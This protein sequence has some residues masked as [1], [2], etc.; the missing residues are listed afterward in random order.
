MNAGRMTPH[1]FGWLF[2][3]ALACA[4]AATPSARADTLVYSNGFE[5]P[6]GAEWSNPFVSTT[7]SGRGF[8]GE[9]G[10][11]PVALSVDGIGAHSSVTVEFEVYIIQTW[12]GSLDRVGPDIWGLRVVDGPGLVQ[13]TFANWGA[14]TAYLGL[15]RERDALGYGQGI[16]GDA[17]Y[18]MSFTFPHSASDLVLEFFASGIGGPG[19]ESWGIDNLALVASS[20]AASPVSSPPDPPTGLIAIA[21]NRSAEVSWTPAAS[22]GTG[23]DRYQVFQQPATR[24][25]GWLL[26]DP[27]TTRV[28]RDVA[29]DG[30]PARFRVM[31]VDTAGN[32]GLSEWSNSV[33]AFWEP[34]PGVNQITNGDFESGELGPWREHGGADRVL[35][36][37][38]PYEGAASLYIRSHGVGWWYG[39]AGIHHL[40]PE[41][42]A[43]QQYTLSAFMKAEAPRMVHMRAYRDSGH[44][45]HRGEHALHVGTEW[46]EYYVQFT[47]ND[48]VLPA[49]VAIDVAESTTGLWV[50]DVRFYEGSYQPVGTHPALAIVEPAV[51]YAV[52][53]GNS[54][55]V[56]VGVHNHADGWHWQVDTPLPASG[57]AGGTAVP[58]GTVANVTGLTPG[59]AHTFYA[60][61]VDGSGNV[62]QPSVVAS[63]QLSVPGD[64]PFVLDDEPKVNDAGYIVSWLHLDEP[65][66]TS[67]GAV[68]A[69]TRDTIGPE[70]VVLA[71]EGGLAPMGVDLLT[72]TWQRINFDDVTEM[73]GL[74]PI[75]HERLQNLMWRH[76]DLSSDFLVTYVRWETSGVV[77]FSF[78]A[79]DTGE[80][81]FNGN[82]LYWSP[83]GNTASARVVAGEWNVLVAGTHESHGG[84][85]FYAHADPAPNAVDDT[86]QY[87][88]LI[89]LGSPVELVSPQRVAPT[90]MF[91]VSVRIAG[92]VSSLDAA[93]VELSLGP[94]DNLMFDHVEVDDTLF[95]GSAVTVN[96][97][98]PKQITF[99]V[100]QGRPAG[101]SG[102]GEIARAYFRAVGAVDS[103]GSVALA[104]AR[105]SSVQAESIRSHV[106]SGTAVVS[107]S[108]EPGDSNG[109]EIVD[110]LDI[111]KIERIV[112][113]LDATPMNA[114]PD[115]N[116]D[117]V[118]NVLDV[119][120]TERLVVGLPAVASA[121]MVARV[122]DVTVRPLR[123][124]EGYAF[125]L[126]LGQTMDMVDT[127][128]LELLYPRDAYAVAEVETFGLPSDA[129]LL[130]NSE[131]G[132]MRHVRN[133]RGLTGATLP[134]IVARTRLLETS[135]GD[136]PPVT[137]RVLIGDTS[138]R[139][140][141]S[142]DFHI[143][144]MRVPAVTAAL[145]NFPNPFNP[146]TWIPFDLAEQESVVVRVYDI[147]GALVRTLDLGRL[148]AGAYADRSRAA[149]WDGRNDAGEP[150]AG[151]VYHYEIRAGDYRATRRMVILK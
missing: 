34:Q 90:S 3:V 131:P 65:I 113:G 6:V 134:D 28:V 96:A 79:D 84:W 40:L 21:G 114:S 9:F 125:D 47:A 104:S 83:S 81:Y 145:P 67:V 117:G 25:D 4:L 115:A 82:R 118:T 42:R 41:L 140:L 70:S 14:E 17:V 111:T 107:L 26:V 1:C 126:V 69:L 77:D 133:V 54:V 110:V 37:T 45:N 64:S 127:V 139:A 76:R 57:P 52:L 51:Q 120:S 50:D 24:N 16:W 2:P 109:D 35:E 31:A 108:G 49:G 89:D 61:L 137:L 36:T 136:A 148:P 144:M 147:G 116:L 59:V 132:R 86:G 27:A 53:D 58:T 72:R 129:T 11:V 102:P 18:M 80:A 138:G 13:T 30:T 33:V 88:H 66:Q 29:T 71:T 150:V 78:V 123:S 44:R 141:V 95:E 46:R 10:A 56:L 15:P 68:Q 149:Y 142:R 121:P 101:V 19:D 112:A 93:S 92:D 20:N 39:D 124:D 74:P 63:T 98:D 119:T 5:S 7:P 130:T 87:A 143:P 97:T 106:A 23:L 55:N 12:D 146:E 48:D 135:P 32:I 103:E 151:G 38:N 60:T 128:Y 73:Q 100:N 75:P 8:L 105:L 22:Q 99:V 94:D 43:G 62:L 122:P 91:P 85:R